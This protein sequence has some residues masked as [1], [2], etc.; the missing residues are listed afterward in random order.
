MSN[1]HKPEVP[2]ERARI[3]ENN[4]RVEPFHDNDGNPIGPL[5]IWMKKEKAPGITI[6]RCIGDSIAHKVGVIAVPEFIDFE[7]TTEH[8]FIVLATDGVWEFMDNK[9]CMELIIPFWKQN[10][11]KGACEQVVR[12]ALTLWRRED[13]VVDDITITIVFLG[14]N[15]CTSQS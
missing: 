6:T 8:K 3:V 13:D 15:D 2:E 10:D 14:T 11:P 9:K 1:D 5:R 12:E 4:G 7:I